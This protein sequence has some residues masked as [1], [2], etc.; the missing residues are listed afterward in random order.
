MH[1][2]H[3]LLIILT[4]RQISWMENCTSCYVDS[5]KGYQL[6]VYT[7]HST[8]IFSAKES[9]QLIAA[10]LGK[11]WEGFLPNRTYFVGVFIGISIY[12]RRK[13]LTKFIIPSVIITI[14]EMCTMLDLLPNPTKSISLIIPSGFWIAV[15]F[16]SFTNHITFLALDRSLNV[17]LKTRKIEKRLP[18]LL[19]LEIIGHGLLQLLGYLI[20]PLKEDEV[21]DTLRYFLSWFLFML[22]GVWNTSDHELPYNLGYLR[23]GGTSG[24]WTGV[25]GLEV[26]KMKIIWGVGGDWKLVK[27]A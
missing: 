10:E 6:T 13:T 22:V 18:S 26:K 25:K 5:S 9:F 24:S 20:L 21:Y 12:L 19:L 27:E 11:G 23:G 4:L 17:L 14:F 16:A 8:L 3:F 1:V 15:I 2:Y 7:I